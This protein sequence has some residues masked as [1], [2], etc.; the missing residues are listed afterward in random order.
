VTGALITA[1]TTVAR[2]GDLYLF[3]AP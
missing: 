2:V 1:D 3:G